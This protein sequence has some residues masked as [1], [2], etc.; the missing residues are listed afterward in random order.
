VHFTLDG[1]KQ[2]SVGPGETLRLTEYADYQI[3]FDRGDQSGTATY[4]IYE[5]LYEFAQTDRGWEL[6]R[7]KED[8][9]MAA[10]PAE[11]PAPADVPPPPAAEPPADAPPPPLPANPE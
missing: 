8:A 9:P 3:S 4:T 1:Q 2:M 5:G 10:A 11:A 6:F 7:Q